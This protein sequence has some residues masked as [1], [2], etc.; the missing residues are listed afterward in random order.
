MSKAKT[1][2]VVTAHPDDE[3]IFFAGTIQRNARNTHII[4]VT[5]ANADGRSKQRGLEFSSSCKALGVTSFEMWDF[6]D[7]YEDR[8]DTKRLSERLR[9]LKMPKLGHVYTHGP[10]GE[11]GHPHHQDVCF[12]VSQAFEQELSIRYCAYNFFPSERIFLSEKEFGIKFEILTQIYSQETQRFLD[13]LPVTWCEGFNSFSREEIKDIYDK[14][15]QKDSSE[16]LSP[17]LQI[18]KQRAKNRPF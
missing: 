14:L 9:N 1:H 12:A 6:P 18:Y 15:C 3:A 7:V 13:V 11:Y 16:Q 4:C 10:L 8:L 17:L 5:D 2:L